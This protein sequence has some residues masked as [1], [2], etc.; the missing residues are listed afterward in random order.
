[1]ARPEA[2]RTDSGSSVGF[3]SAVR[4]VPVGI[5]LIRGAAEHTD[6]AHVAQ[7]LSAPPLLPALILLGIVLAAVSIITVVRSLPVTDRR[8]LLID[9]VGGVIAGTVVWMG[10]VGPAMLP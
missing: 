1:M 6:E 5:F 10:L 7:A 2:S 8:A 3:A 9:L 4:F